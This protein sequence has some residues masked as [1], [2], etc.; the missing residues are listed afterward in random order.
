VYVAID[1]PDEVQ[2]VR[3]EA[4]RPQQIPRAESAAPPSD[5]TVAPNVE[6]VEVTPIT[7][8]D[9]IDGVVG[10]VNVPSVV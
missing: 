2:L 8:G 6:E 4:V 7:V 3:G 1:V 9:E 10:V 5:V